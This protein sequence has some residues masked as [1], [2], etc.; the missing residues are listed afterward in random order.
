MVG[1]GFNIPSSLTHNSNLVPIP[2]AEILTFPI[3]KFCTSAFGADFL[4]FFTHLERLLSF[5][6]KWE[7]SIVLIGSILYLEAEIELLKD[8]G[9]RGRRQSVIKE[10]HGS[11]GKDYSYWCY[12]LLALLCV[13]FL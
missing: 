7:A 6:L 8:K 11:T 3:R 10:R 1:V 2:N 4:V 5:Q 12:F 9:G 13:F